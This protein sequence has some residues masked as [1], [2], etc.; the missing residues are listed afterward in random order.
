MGKGATKWFEV[1]FVPCKLVIVEVKKMLIGNYQHNIDPKGR[2]IMPSKFR[3]ELGDIFYATKGKDNTITILSK[4]AWD[5][6]GRKIA[7]MPSA[8]TV[9]ITRFLFSSAAELVPDKQG[10]VLIPQ[11]LR[12]YAGLDK[13]VVINGTGSKVEIWDKDAWESYNAVLS[14][15]DVYEMMDELEL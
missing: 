12:E 6:L 14:G 5:E 15:D 13:D 1:V 8:R 2:V 3:D 4:A 10:R 11:P 9:Q 7:A